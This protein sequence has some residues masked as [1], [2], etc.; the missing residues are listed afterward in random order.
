MTIRG[1]T[2]IKIGPPYHT[3]VVGKINRTKPRVSCYRVRS[4]DPFAFVVAF[5]VASVNECH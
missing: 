4:T 1:E 2:L 5:F 3:A